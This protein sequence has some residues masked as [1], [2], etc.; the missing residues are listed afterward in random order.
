MARIDQEQNDKIGLLEAF[1]KF[2]ESEG[3]LDSDWR[4]EEPFAIDEFL[5]IG[6][7]HVHRFTI[8]KNKNKS[9]VAAWVCSCGKI[10]HSM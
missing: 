9:G 8:T 1:A 2:L 4:T 6:R 5:K 7:K 3:Y 10:V